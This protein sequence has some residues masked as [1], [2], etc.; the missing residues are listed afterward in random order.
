MKTRRDINLQLAC[1]T[2][3]E[4]YVESK[5][6][7]LIGN[8]SYGA[9]FKVKYCG[10]PCAAKEI[11]SLLFEETEEKL[12][13]LNVFSREC[14]QCSELNHK[15]I[16]KF[17]GIYFPNNQLLP[18]MLMELMD[19]SLRVYLESP[20]T[21]VTLTTKDS[22]LIDVAEGL[23]YLHHS[24]PPVVHRDLTP[25]NILLKLPSD[26]ESAPVAKISDL[27]VAKAVETN[28]KIKQRLTKLPG[29]PGFMP[30]EAFEEN[31][32]Y[33]TSLDI[34]S[35]GGV[36]LFVANQIWPDPSMPTKLD[37][38][39]N[40][41]VAFTEVQRRQKY[42]NG[43][44]DGV[45]IWRALVESCLNNKPDNRPTIADVSERLKSFKVVKYTSDVYLD[46]TI[47]LYV[48]PYAW[49]FWGGKGGILPP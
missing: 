17:I 11:H 3:S 4:S 39:T 7:I 15:N 35:Y 13:L 46:L 48:C 5:D 45:E 18:V 9:V 12:K 19:S 27:G 43:M 28:K 31:P 20:L 6:K 34:F 22:I 8:G 42:L 47:K 44:K 38:D 36:V 1:I 49:F 23:S 14:C 33:N 29:T 40:Q 26:E 41:L 30:P 21:R 37:H 16:V 32:V 24:N 10:K 2:V 25:N